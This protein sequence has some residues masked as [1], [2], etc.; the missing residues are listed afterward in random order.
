M[1]KDHLVDVDSIDIVK[2]A[3]GEE[4]EWNVPMEV[5]EVPYEK[6]KLNNAELVKLGCKWCEGK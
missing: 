6:V 5:I 1:R 4:F 2:W 3:P